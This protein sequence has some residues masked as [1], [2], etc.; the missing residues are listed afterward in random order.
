[1]RSALI[2]F[3]LLPV[4]PARAASREEI[5]SAATRAVALVQKGSSGFAQMMQCF[6][7]HDHGLPLLMEHVAREHGVPVDEA[8]AS[9]VAAKAFVGT[10][11]LSSL[12]QA[13]QDPMI[14]DPAPS[15]GWALVAAHSVG[16]KPSLISAVFARRIASWQRPDGHWPTGDDRPPQS[17]SL[18]TATAVALR[19]MHFDM[20]PQLA[21]ET[22]ERS[23]RARQWLLSTEPHSTEDFTFR[24]FGLHFANATSS[25]VHHAAQELLA[26]QHSDGCSRAERIFMKKTR[27][28]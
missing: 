18:F 3:L 4:L 17:Y 26:L 9:Q 28:A 5:R 25:D 24:L 27:T 8:A 19:A 14:V 21:Q 22:E 16:V 6:S 12:D 1:M 20:P 10:T 11:N 7:C 23:A 13:V 2:L 15:D